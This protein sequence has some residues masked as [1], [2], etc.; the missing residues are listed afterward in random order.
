MADGSHPFT[1]VANAGRSGSTWLYQVL[2]RNCADQGT[3]YHEAMLASASRPREF[4]RA[5]TPAARHRVA[6]DPRVGAWMEAWRKKLARGPVIECGWTAAHLAPVLAEQFAGQFRIV[7]LHRHPVEFAASKATAGHFAGGF[8]NRQHELDPMME[9]AIHREFTD[10]WDRMVPFEK[11][12][13]VWLEGTSRT[14]EFLERTPDVPQLVVAMTD[15]IRDR[16]RLR[17]VLAFC[18]L[19]PPDP[20]DLAVDRN[21]VLTNNREEFALGDSWRRYSDHPEVVTAG[22]AHGYS[23]A[24]AQLAPGMQRYQM[25]DG[26]GARIRHATRYHSVRRR[27]HVVRVDAKRLLLDHG[28]RPGRSAAQWLGPD[29]RVWAR[30]RGPEEEDEVSPVRPRSDTVR[31]RQRPRG[32]R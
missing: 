11:C 13:F 23:M 24:S 6:S 5:Y 7:H 17:E 10:R 19:E 12:L 32:R 25:P 2:A 18:G 22:E 8:R 1:L 26:L 14:D 3:F 16:Q 29:P 28:G 9:A 15:M 30:A 21:E 20:L 27:L 31:P 4:A